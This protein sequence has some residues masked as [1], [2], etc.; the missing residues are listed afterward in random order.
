MIEPGVSTQ[1]GAVKAVDFYWNF[2]FRNSPKIEPE[3]YDRL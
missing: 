1:G 3:E 2:H